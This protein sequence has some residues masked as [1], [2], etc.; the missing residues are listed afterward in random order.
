MSHSFIVVNNPERWPL[1]V[2]GIEVVSARAY[3]SEPRFSALRRAKI[4]NLCRSYRYQTLGYYVSLLAE[5]RGHR[6]FPRIATVE[7]MKFQSLVRTVSSDLDELI[8]HTLA[9][10]QGDTFTLSIYFA[11]NLAKRYDRLCRHL[12]NLFPVP[13]LRAEFARRD[14]GWAL[15]SISPISA[16]DIPQDH[17]PAVADLALAYFARGDD[18]VS[19]RTPARYR[20]AILTDASET[21]PPSNARALERFV[22]AAERC[23]FAAEFIDKDDYGRLAEFDA[24]FIRQT[25]AVNNATYRFARRAEAEGLVVIDDSASIVRCTNKVFL[26][27]LLARH[28]L[29][30]PRTM[31]VH[32]DNVDEVL[33]ALGL[34]CVLKQPDSAFSLG[35][36]KATSA[37][38]YRTH[39]E[40]LLDDSDLI[41]AQEFLPTSFDWRIGVLDRRPLYACKYHMARNH[42]Q[43][44]DHS[45][46]GDDSL[47]NCT[48]LPVEMA[49]RRIV[50]L[51]VK[52]ANLIGSGFYGVDLKEIGR[53][54]CVV[55]V[56]DNP[57]IDAGVE[58]RVL[59]DRLYDAVM[60][61][62]LS[63]LERRSETRS[64]R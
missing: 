18:R 23:D 35:V 16:N 57:S 61:T 45:K 5:A 50:Q 20:L 10:L 34:P 1:A 25:T 8:Q 32:R 52:A 28:R 55:E 29:P 47:G 7:D 11:R 6:P 60:E 17:R 64:W 43:I 40:R 37:E 9:P 42:W 31:V 2:P 51:A 21:N 13:L 14:D 27:E 19:R 41:V 15:Q 44:Y 53:R 49:P 39:V 3:L 62:F 30:G 12:F 59:R 58:D 54:A 46:A 22:E 56:N 48:T 36:V 26:S 63:R 38:E 4:Y 33:A 24:L